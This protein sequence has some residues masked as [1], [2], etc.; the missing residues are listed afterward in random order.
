[1]KPQ[2]VK[3]YIPKINEISLEFVE[4]IVQTLDKDNFAPKNFHFMINQWSLE[5][6]G[7]IALNKRLNVLDDNNKDE[8]TQKIINVSS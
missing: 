8:R 1:M 7:Y 4:K 3:L 6:I 2:T 5:S